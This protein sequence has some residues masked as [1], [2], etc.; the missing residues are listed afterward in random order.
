MSRSSYASFDLGYPPWALDF[1]PHNR[2]YLLVGGGGGEGQKE[3]PNRLTLLDISSQGSIEKAAELDILEDSPVSLG[4]LSAKDG[5][6]GYAGIN[7][8]KAERETGKNEHLRSFKVDFPAKSK[9]SKT[10]DAKLSPLSKTTLFS[11]SYAKSGDAFQRVLRLSPSQSGSVSGKRI[12]AIASSLA[13]KS[14]I[15]V[16]NAT[17]A[18]PTARDV[19]CRI[20]PPRNVEANDVDIFDLANGQ[21]R[22]AYITSAELFSTDIAYDFGGS[23]VKMAVKEPTALHQAPTIAGK[24]RAKYK[25][26]RFLSAEYILV[27]VNVQSASELHIVRYYPKGGPGNVILRKRLPKRMGAAV[28]LDVCP[29]DIDQKTG[30]RQLVVAVAAQSQDLALFTI[31]ITTNSPPTTIQHFKDVNAAH[32]APMKKVALSSFTSPYDVAVASDKKMETPPPKQ[33]YLRLASIS[34][35]NIVVVDNFSLQTVS[36]SKPGRPR[37]VIQKPGSIGALLHKGTNIFV[38][39]FVLLVSLLL[40]QSLLDGWAAQQGNAPAVQLIPSQLRQAIANFRQDS[41]PLKSVIH[42]AVHSGAVP[43]GKLRDFI[44]THHEDDVPRDEQKKAIVI[45]LPGEEA[46]AEG[47]LTTEV[48]H[49]TATVVA[50]EKVKSWDD[51][52]KGEK[53]NWKRRLASAGAWATDE[54][55]TVLKSIFFSE[56]AGAVGRAAMEAIQG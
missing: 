7:S 15:V 4:V 6:Y 22:L 17:T 25:C 21:F 14:E 41:D 23:K 5:L 9:G 36:S 56:V 54:G 46:A 38:V 45:R 1:D 44:D 33:Q 18:S 43:V 27:L 47:G 29:L 8:V 37:Y 19:I 28:S 55:E 31:D 49:D 40:A 24:S 52:S 20:E 48:H 50:D 11:P 26:L 35:S 10:K 12:G 53:E 42:E 39:A 3:V 51:L 30:A 32:D 16:F 34:L 13:E 2:G